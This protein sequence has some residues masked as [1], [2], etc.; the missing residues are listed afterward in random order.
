MRGEED[1]DGDGEEECE[2]EAQHGRC[3]GRI[4]R[5]GD[6]RGRRDGAAAGAAMLVGFAAFLCHF[7]EPWGEVF[8]GG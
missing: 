7:S 4:V 1:L 6:G 5:D 3:H 2:S 8:R